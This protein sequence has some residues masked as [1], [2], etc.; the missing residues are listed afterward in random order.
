MEDERGGLVK[1]QRGR[2]DMFKPLA[3]DGTVWR[4]GDGME[5]ERNGNG[6]WMAGM[7]GSNANT[8][9]I[10]LCTNVAPL[11]TAKEAMVV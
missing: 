6:G 2:C 8:I 10:V 3:Q 9:T 11:C 5:D 7:A 1:W 4:K